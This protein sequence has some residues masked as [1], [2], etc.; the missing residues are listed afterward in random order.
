MKAW[1][2]PGDAGQPRAADG[3]DNDKQEQMSGTNLIGVG[4]GPSVDA[5][6]RGVETTFGEPYDIPG[7]EVTSTNGLEGTIPI[8]GLSGD[9][10]ARQ[11]SGYIPWVGVDGSGK[12]DLCPPFV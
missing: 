6:V 8:E 3:R 4:K 11:S 9:L 1:Q 2:S 5:V 10:R 12:T 7:L